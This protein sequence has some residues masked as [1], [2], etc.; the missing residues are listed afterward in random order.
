MVGKFLGLLLN[1]TPNLY[2]L[3]VL[4]K[5]KKKKQQQNHH[6]HANPKQPFPLLP[7]I[8]Q[9]THKKNVILDSYKTILQDA[10]PVKLIF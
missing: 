1:Q 3:E 7:P 5:L 8:I 6:Q 2:L 4:E 9:T 10:I